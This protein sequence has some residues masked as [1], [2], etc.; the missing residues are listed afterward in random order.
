MPLLPANAA[1][2]SPWRNGGG[3]TR[4]IAASPSGAG[5]DAFDWRVSLARIERDGPFSTFPGVDRLIAIVEGEGVELIFEDAS[6][7]VLRRGSPPN[8]FPGEIVVKARLCD[9]P[10]TALNVMTRRG[11]VRASLALVDLKAPLEVAPHEG[12]GLTLALD[13]AARLETSLGAQRLGALDAWQDDASAG[14]TIF[15]EP[16]LR[17]AMLQLVLLAN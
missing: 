17:A 1:R 9:G 14:L 8:R 6:S 7:V 11:S 5:M 10:A 12:V 4:E 13:G 16:L 3:F 15:P 2:E